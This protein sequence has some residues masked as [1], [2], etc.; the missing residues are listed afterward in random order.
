MYLSIYIDLSKTSFLILSF[1]LLS[2]SDIYFSRRDETRQ[3]RERERERKCVRERESV[4]VWV[5]VWEWVWVCV[6]VCVCVCVDGG[7][8]ES[9]CLT[10]LESACLTQ[11]V[12][13]HD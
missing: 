8:L 12:G 2:L 4:W 10:H 5:W 13:I 7:S 6:C 11:T 9:A 1:R 3:E